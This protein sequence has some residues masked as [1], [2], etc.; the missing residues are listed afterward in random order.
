ME[1]AKRES[2]YREHRELRME[3]GMAPALWKRLSWP[4]VIAG[5]VVA[6]TVQVWLG[7]IGLAIGAAVADPAATQQ[8]FAGLGVFGIIWAMLTVIGALFAGGWI[9]ARLANVPRSSDGTM[10]GVITWAATNVVVFYLMTTAVAGLF[11]TIGNIATGA[12]QGSPE[13]I[14]ALTEQF[15]GGAAAENGQAADTQQVAEQATQAVA[16]AS[17]WLAFVMFLG[18]ISAGAGGYFGRPKERVEFSRL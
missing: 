5:T 13:Q 18:L 3:R 11:G 12:L 17:G 9:A 2:E 1:P 6:L 15:G 8:P 4:S 10:H 7:L 14:G 16:R